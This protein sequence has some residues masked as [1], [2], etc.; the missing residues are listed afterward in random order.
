VRGALAV[1]DLL[2]VVEVHQQE[3]V[4]PPVGTRPFGRFGEGGATRLACS[5]AG[6]EQRFAEGSAE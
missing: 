1:V 4:A 6:D 2:E 5:T 3:R